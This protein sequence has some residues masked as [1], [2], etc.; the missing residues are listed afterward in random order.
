MTRYALRLSVILSV[1]LLFIIAPL[2]S[3]LQA[4]AQLRHR[5]N[6]TKPATTSTAGIITTYA[7]NGFGHG[8]L[9]GGFAGDGGA[10]TS[11][12]LSGPAGIAM[13]SVGNMYIADEFNH[14]IRR[15]DAATGIITTVAGGGACPPLGYGY[16]GD[17]G[18]ATSAALD[19][20]QGVAV[21]SSGNIFIADIGTSTIRKV[22]AKTQI[23]TTVAGFPTGCEIYPGTAIQVCGANPGYSG[24]GG[25]ATMA[26]VDSP[27]SV[28]VD[29]EGN[30]YI[31]DTGSDAVRKVTASSGIITTIAGG[32]SGCAQQTDLLGDGCPATSASLSGPAQV[33]FDPAGNMYI[34]DT[35]Q[36]EGAD[37]VRSMPKQE[38]LPPMPAVEMV[39]AAPGRLTTLEAAAPP[40]MPSS[41]IP[42][43]SPLT[44]PAISISPTRT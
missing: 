4:R 42:G 27:E 8:S 44:H 11:A 37:D 7:G 20:P 9:I 12:E 2:S 14:R 29:A 25:P 26:Q 6:S 3:R 36:E 18:L 21:D 38:S 35:I 19:A 17:N 5:P 24:D 23:I 40:P 33:A 41:T 1:V 39:Q 13:D 10:A 34:A 22:D 32:G 28:T 15:V 31:S 16:C 30:L 43:R